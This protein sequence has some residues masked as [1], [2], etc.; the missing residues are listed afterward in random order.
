M[1]VVAQVLPAKIDA[2]LT[3]ESELFAEIRDFREAWK[4]A[5]AYIGADDPPLIEAERIDDATS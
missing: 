1:K 4:L 2:T 3:V 5:R